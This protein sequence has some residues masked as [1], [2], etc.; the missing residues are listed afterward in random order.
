M[1]TEY[2]TLSN[3]GEAQELQPKAQLADQVKGS[4]TNGHQ[5]GGDML[6]RGMLVSE[7]TLIAEVVCEEL[8]QRERICATP[9]GCTR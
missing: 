1:S 7:G 3:S 4:L 9:S 6:K 8:I 5:Q 2:I